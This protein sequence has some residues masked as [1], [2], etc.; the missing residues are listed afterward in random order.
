MKYAT[1]LGNAG[2][3]A[4]SLANSKPASHVGRVMAKQISGSNFGV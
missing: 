2:M 4:V 1:A 3:F